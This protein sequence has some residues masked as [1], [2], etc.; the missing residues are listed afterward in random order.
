MNRQC[1]ECTKCCEG[2]FKINVH[3]NMVTFNKPCVFAIKNKG[4]A[5]HKTKPSPCSDFSCAWLK[6]LF[7]ED[8]RPDKSNVIGLFDNRE[9]HL[10]DYVKLIETAQDNKVDEIVEWC[11]DRDINTTIESYHNH[12]IPMSI[13]DL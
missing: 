2:H 9:T 6:G 5:I 11:D 7:D 4:C 13:V 10:I 3:G 12:S 1:G 8:M